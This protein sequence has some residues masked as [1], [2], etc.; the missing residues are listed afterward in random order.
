MQDLRAAEESLR[1]AM[2]EHEETAGS[3]RDQ[4][5]SLQV[6]HLQS[7][8]AL[9]AKCCWLRRHCMSWRCAEVP[10]ASMLLARE[11]KVTP[12]WLQRKLDAEKAQRIA[13]ISRTT[14]THA[15]LLADANQRIKQLEVCV[16][17]QG[18]LRLVLSWLTF[19]L[20]VF[21]CGWLRMLRQISVAM[22]VF[23]DSV[24]TVRPC[25]SPHDS[26][27]TALTVRTG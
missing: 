27:T 9:A 24:M 20:P 21:R 12:C 16:T 1:L 13:D 8:S 6:R 2:R 15:N 11:C 22:S 5:F 26:G 10:L 7:Q 3:S 19:L 23:L 14:H 4:A 18:T 17:H 25:C